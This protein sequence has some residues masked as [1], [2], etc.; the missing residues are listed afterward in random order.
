MWL[1]YFLKD[2]EALLR[3]KEFVIG[4]LKLFREELLICKEFYEHRCGKKMQHR[5]ARN[6]NKELLNR[7]LLNKIFYSKDPSN[8]ETDFSLDNLS[9]LIAETS[10]EELIDR[11]KAAHNH[12]SAVDS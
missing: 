2:N 6:S 7:E 8:L 1:I 5:A 11:I 4:M 9:A 10:I 12:L 3:N